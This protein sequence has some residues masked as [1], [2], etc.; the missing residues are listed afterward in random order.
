MTVDPRSFHYLLP[1]LTLREVAD[2]LSSR[3]TSG[4]QLS[5][6]HV[7]Q[8]ALDGL[9]PLAI[10]FLNPV[11]A[12]AEEVSRADTTVTELDDSEYECLGDDADELKAEGVIS[13]KGLADLP[14]TGQAGVC[15]ARQHQ[16]LAFGIAHAW[17]E[18]DDWIR[19]SRDG[20]IYRLFRWPDKPE[21][22]Q[23]W[24]DVPPPLKATDL[25]S[26]AVLVI[27]TTDFAKFQ[28]SIGDRDHGA[29]LAPSPAAALSDISNAVVGDDQVLE[30]PDLSTSPGRKAAVD[31]LLAEANKHTQVKIIRKHLH[32]AMKHRQPR[33]FQYWQSMDKQA[34]VDT[35]TRMIEMLRGGGE[36]LVALLERQR[37]L[38]HS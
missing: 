8:L 20:V 30:E 36:E 29:L 32:L 19:F 25:P 4:I 35:N 5:E 22:W 33:Q 38:K 24:D 12:K 2:R 23:D 15:V 13:L 37:L 9:L 11:P 1:Y 34:T 14:L 7:L 26:D 18:S 28:E 6:A 21:N 27:R 31:R 3:E 10:C 17:P 16:E